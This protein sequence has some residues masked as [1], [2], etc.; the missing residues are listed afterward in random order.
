MADDTVRFTIDNSLILDALGNIDRTTLKDFESQVKYITRALQ[1]A[2]NSI[3]NVTKQLD[4]AS[5][6]YKASFS[7]DKS[8]EINARAVMKSVTTELSGKYSY[9]P[10]F[11]HTIQE[12]GE[13]TLSFFR[14]LRGSRAKKLAEEFL[15][16]EGAIESAPTIKNKDRYRVTYRVTD[17]GYKKVLDELGSEKKAKA[18][19]SAELSRKLNKAMSASSFETRYANEK[20]KEKE[21]NKDASKK[22]SQNEENKLKSIAGI[23]T[24]LSRIFGKTNIL[25][26]IATTAANLIR[27]L[28][29]AY[30]SNASEIQK[31]S[32]TA[33][34]IS[35][36]RE[37]V[38]NYQSV[39]RAMGLEEGTFVSAIKSLQAN[40]GDI[41]NL[42]EKALGE[43]AKVLGGDV[44]KA[45][46]AGLGQNDPNSLM[47]TI[48]D[49][50]FTRGQQGINSIGLYVGQMEAQRELATALEKAGL[51]ELATVLRNMNYINQS[52]LYKGQIG[53]VNPFADYM[54]LFRHYTGG[55]SR[56]DYT[57]AELNDQLVKRINSR[58]DDV[59]EQIKLSFGTLFG[60]L[61]NI[62]LAIDNNDFGKS[63]VERYED[64]VKKIK[65]VDQARTYL[66]SEKEAM[67]DLFEE[68][69]GS[70]KG[71]VKELGFN[72][73]QELVTYIAKNN[74]TSEKALK[75]KFKGK[76]ADY[77]A[78]AQFFASEQGQEALGYLAL[79]EAMQANIDDIDKQKEKA[80]KDAS[81]VVFDP[82]W[83]LGEYIQGKA[84]KLYAGGSDEFRDI[85]GFKSAGLPKPAPSSINTA[86]EDFYQAYID[87]VFGGAVPTYDE[88]IAT[89]VTQHL[90]DEIFAELAGNGAF[91]EISGDFAS[92]RA[93]NPAWANLTDSEVGVRWAY[94]KGL[95]KDEDFKN[96][97]LRAFSRGTSP[98]YLD[99]GW[100]ITPS[101]YQLVHEYLMQ[102]RDMKQT[103][104]IGYVLLRRELESSGNYVSEFNA[105]NKY[106]GTITFSNYDAEKQTVDI[107]IS[108]T[109]ASGKKSKVATIETD[110]DL[111]GSPSKTFT[112]EA[113]SSSARV[114][115]DVR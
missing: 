12:E 49:A 72:S 97:M 95:V 6:L 37:T 107:N 111:A 100:G 17:S 109:D 54:N 56:L 39:E 13:K 88:L 85:S 24:F 73:V 87:L 16:S 8:Q 40:F 43:L 84:T 5:G 27:R 60:H 42:N 58:I 23:A 74:I 89:G 38:R 105:L 32:A 1:S 101:N 26:G 29:T 70:I 93:S 115:E 63:P 35:V 112:V 25:I 76:E 81:S 110:K 65:D 21:K 92:L 14:K 52:P 104:D 33:E 78:V 80:K 41:S 71:N 22:A 108:Y 77:Q 30:L 4:P 67:L 61:T 18:Y 94:S 96:S 3:V 20:E 9:E 34:G 7:V 103:A 83:V 50:Y 45:V 69:A 66:S 10:D 11:V 68:S 113:T 79:A 51:G 2:T 28:L 91:G 98:D 62:L 86:G 46:E 99:G 59:K 90:T 19:F 106:G 64:R 75:K 82:R 15:G 57:S 31:Q 102:K 114:K 47:K 44:I 36:S 53:A 55:T 48:L